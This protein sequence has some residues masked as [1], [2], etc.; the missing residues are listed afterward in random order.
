[1]FDTDKVGQAGQILS[2]LM[3]APE[4]LKC[5]GQ[6]ARERALREFSA[7]KMVAEYRLLYSNLGL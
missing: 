3:A 6:A 1:L 4:L 2:R 7:S 5:A